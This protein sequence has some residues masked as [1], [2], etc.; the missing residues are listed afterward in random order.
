MS[1]YNTFSR[2]KREENA[3]KP[4]SHKEGAFAGDIGETGFSRM[5]QEEKVSLKEAGVYIITY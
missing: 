4:Q 5:A 1:L 3:T 2:Q